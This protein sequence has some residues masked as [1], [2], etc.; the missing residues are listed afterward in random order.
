MRYFMYVIHIINTIMHCTS[1][2]QRLLRSI[3]VVKKLKIYSLSE[4]LLLCKKRRGG[5]LYGSENKI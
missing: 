3:L 2:A 4:K 5:R 1:N